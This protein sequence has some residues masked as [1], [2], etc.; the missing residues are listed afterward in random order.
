MNIEQKDK[1]TNK[2]N[3][4]DVVGVLSGSRVS[5]PKKRN[6]GQPMSATGDGF[7]NFPSELL[8]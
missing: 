6:S 1:T 5:Q 8:P 2:E 7:T 4:N 3:V